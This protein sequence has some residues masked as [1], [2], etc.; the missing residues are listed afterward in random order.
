MK[1]NQKIIRILNELLE[2]NRD[3]ILGYGEAVDQKITP[4]LRA[5]F[6]RAISMR[7]QFAA[8]LEDEIIDLEG[9]PAKETSLTD[10]LHRAWINLKSAWSDWEEQTVI[11][12]CILG[13]KASLRD[14][15]KALEVF[16]LPLA[17][18]I[19]LLGHQS[20]I[21]STIEELETM[22]SNSDGY[23]VIE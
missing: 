15:Q 23:P 8:E 13:E 7:E 4:G 21:S 6:R 11:E 3:A 9:E 2:K 17:T 1:T 22:E 16:D 19:L 20:S 18:E 12:E 14:Y 10:K 5:Y